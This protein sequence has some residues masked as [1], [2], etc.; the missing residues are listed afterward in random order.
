MEKRSTLE[1]LISDARA[2]PGLT[3]EEVQAIMGP[4]A[5]PEADDYGKME[6]VTSI[7]NLQVFPGTIYL[8]ENKVELVYVGSRGLMDLNRDDLR[9]LFGDNAVPLRSR[10]GKRANLWVYAQQGVACA[11]LD[12]EL[13][14]FEVFQPCTQREYEARFYLD[15]GPFIR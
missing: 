8:R 11:S 5:I 4:A 13:K 1:S 15:P 2:F 3:I 7:E 12:G 6:D 9:T 10:A 14:Y